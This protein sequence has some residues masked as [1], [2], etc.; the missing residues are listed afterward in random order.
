MKAWILMVMLVSAA[1][2]QA[3]AT[4]DVA[5]ER[6]AKIEIFA[7]GPVGYAGITS[8]G[9]KDYK[10][11]LSRP[12]ALADFEKLLSTGNA[13]GKSYALVGIR[14]VN[15]DHFKILSTS[16]RDS[17]ADVTTERGCIVS[18]ESLG[19]V[20]RRIEAGDYSKNKSAVGQSR[21]Q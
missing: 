21:G 3:P 20:L 1:S 6:L 13:Q 12:S 19:S 11:I 17:N 5:L 8:Q 15:P 9:E 4:S 2:A 16:L 10:L 7:F 14:A 18:H